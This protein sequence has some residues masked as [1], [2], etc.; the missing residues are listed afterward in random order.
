MGHITATIALGPLLYVQGCHVRRVTP[1]LP[2]PPGARQGQTGAGPELR[3]LILGDSAAAGVG[4]ATQDE[5]LSGRL[6]AALSP[7]YCVSWRL[8]ARSGAKT[9]EIVACL[10]AMP[11]EPFDIVVSSLGVNDV[12]SGQGRRRWLASQ[13]QLVEL[14]RQ[15]F[16]ARL[17]LLSSLPPMHA[18]PALPQPLRWYLG[19]QARR[20]NQ[21]L[22]GWV[23]SSARCHFITTDL[24][25]ET[26]LMAPDGF[27]PGPALYAAWG[28]QLAESI[29][30][31]CPPSA[32]P[33]G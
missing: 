3:V 12:T 8:M 1:V 29:R 13:A 15:K 16:G 26:G 31:R 4:A 25:Q 5:A 24:P 11:G 9:H 21:A 7:H 20:F 22:A 10:A 23:R 17:V 27:H 19:A 18:F 28:A 14:L 6:V 32:L 33:G 2:E 30:S